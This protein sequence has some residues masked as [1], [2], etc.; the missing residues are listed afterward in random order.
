MKILTKLKKEKKR[1][2]NG[3]P[4]ML[5]KKNTK[6]DLIFFFNVNFKLSFLLIK[7]DYIIYLLQKFLFLIIKKQHILLLFDLAFF[8][9]SRDILYAI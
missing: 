4:C 6:V 1:K 9:P 8:I 3:V 7:L 2:E 5:V